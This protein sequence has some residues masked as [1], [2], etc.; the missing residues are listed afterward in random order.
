MAAKQINNS[1]FYT[2]D[3][4]PSIYAPGGE[5]DAVSNKVDLL[6]LGVSFLDAI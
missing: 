6:S 3:A 5:H 2:A 1:A 4:A